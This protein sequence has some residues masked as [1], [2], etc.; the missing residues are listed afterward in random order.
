MRTTIWQLLFSVVVLVAVTACATRE[1]WT[2]WNTHATHFASGEHMF[3]SVKNREGRTAAV[4][5]TDVA[6]AREEGWW[7][8]P[9]TISQEN[10]LE[11]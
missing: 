6:S 3:F 9:V 7:G 4:T 10:I 8:R 5:R 2:T 11:R 1:D